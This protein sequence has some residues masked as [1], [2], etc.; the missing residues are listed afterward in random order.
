MNDYAERVEAGR[1]AAGG[2]LVAKEKA[3]DLLGA[4]LRPGA[5][6]IL[7]GN[8]QKQ[9]RFLARALLAAGP[10][11][12]LHG[13]HLLMSAVSLEEH[14]ALF[15]QGIADRLD[16][17]FSGLQAKGMARL[18]RER[19]IQVGA[20]HTYLEL[21]SR[22]LTDLRPDAALLAGETAD[23][24]GNV[25]LGSNGEETAFLCEAVRGAGGVTMVQVES[26]VNGPLPREDLP[27]DRVDFVIVCGE[28][29]HLVPLFTRDPARITPRQ[30]LMAMMVIKGIYAP[31]EVRSL[32]HG[33]GYATA[34][35]ELLL[36]T[37][38]ESLGLKGRVATHWVLNPHPTLIP[39]IEA[40]WVRSI[41]SFGSEVGME[42]Y[43][44][45]RPKIFFTS[46]GG[47]LLSNR[48]FAQVAGQYGVDCFVGATLQVDADGNSS[49]ATRD[50]ISGFGGAPN[51]GSDAP[52][53]RHPS[54]AWVKAGKERAEAQSR[55][56]WPSIPF[57]G[58]KLVVQVTP[59]VSE[60]GG[61]P[62]FVPEL[63]SLSLV[64]E[65]GLEVPPIMLYGDDLTHIVTERGIAYL[66]RCA[67]REERRAAIRA[68]AGET[69]V[70]RS[71]KPE[72]TRSLRRRGLVQTPEDLG[73]DLSEV[74]LDRL[75]A[76][77]LADLERISG[78]LY[79]APAGEF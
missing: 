8:N 63:D 50:R 46:P 12:R 24:Q 73:L 70:G 35:I 41:Y 78:G 61:I 23:A 28:R 58:R 56:G 71:E 42:R 17:A 37:F 55:A 33:I 52:G 13:L 25:Y 10:V 36:P 66:L 11:H 67:T 14:L 30:V 1:R 74:S 6:L 15:E 48:L 53:R 76:R 45:A 49:T 47:G 31:Y 29:P 59:T 4:V 18:I 9:A 43:A 3:P 40:G 44:A 26:V 79:T 2:R 16:F 22:Y 51:L 75:A 38:G 64:R 21:Y 68:I 69:P 5:R 77:S 65:G 72:E 20:I 57:R 62:V 32:N 19:K 60:K 7:E 34:A 54:P 27:A 39:A